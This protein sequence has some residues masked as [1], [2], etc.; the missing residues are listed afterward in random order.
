MSVTGGPQTVPEVWAPGHDSVEVD[1]DGARLSMAPLAGD[2]GRG[3]GRGWWRAEAGLAPGTRYRF[4]VDGGAPRPDPR[5]PWQPEGID[6]PSAVVDHGAFEWSDRSW[7]GA[8]L[9]SAV[10]YELHIGTFSPEG[11]FDGA[12]ARLDHLVDLGVSTIEVMPVAEGSGSRGWGYDGSLLWAPHHAYGGP[13]GLK[14]L[15]D[16]AHGGGLAVILD[17][18]YNHLGPAGNYLGEYGPYFTDR[19]QTPWGTAVNFDGPGSDGV[20]R[21][22]VD[23]A[24]MWLRDYHVDGLRLDAVHS[25]FDESA[26]HIL[27][28]LGGEV[29]A[30]ADEVGRSLWLIAES[31]RNDPR[32]V[33]SRQAGGYGL[34]A[35]WSDDFHHALH[36]ALTGDRGGYYED[37]GQLGQ[38]ARA[39]RRVFVYGRDWSPY[40]GRHHG[41]PAGALSGSR[42]V[43]ALQNHDQVG[44]RARGERSSALMTT[45]R[46]QIGAALVMCAPFV[47]MLFQGEEW[48]A[49][50]PF[51]YF[52]DHRD[53]A[54][55][56]AVSEGRRREFAAFGWA[57][58]D[59]PDPQD[60]RTFERSR[61]D[62]SEV[63][64]AP[65]AQLLDWHRRLIGLRRRYGELADGRR[66]CVE[67]TCD[68]GLGWIRLKRGRVTVVANISALTREVPAPAGEIVMASDDSVGW[69]DRAVGLPPDTV[70]IVVSPDT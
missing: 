70:A 7:K 23:N 3:P 31:D 15:V 49:S 11:T 17:V 51:Q 35:S 19:Y 43:G 62:W 16:A 37:F 10:I 44:N 27:E 8:R 41:R 50:T 9:A 48:G 30:L 32:L 36:A 18:V 20:R 56:R 68:E 22:V 53:P 66:D 25:I 26:L 33:R 67:A 59:V 34:D 60:Q 12:V 57:P 21:F 54:L 64:R 4:V 42:F 2:G 63:A 47:P 65:H 39:L 58:D 55:A 5:S 69:R 24:V 46:L 13:Q 28:E 1:L 29:D 14:R 45:G 6:G 40:R 38:L 52:T 61:L